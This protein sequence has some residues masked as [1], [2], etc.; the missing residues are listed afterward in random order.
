[1]LSIPNG[2]QAAAKEPRVAARMPLRVMKSLQANGSGR[3]YAWRRASAQ[4]CR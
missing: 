4:V 1:V 3:R 2:E